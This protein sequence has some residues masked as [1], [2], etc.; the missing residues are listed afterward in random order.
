VIVHL[1]HELSAAG[2]D[3]LEA[4]Q[5]VHV[6]VGITG[7]ARADAPV[8]AAHVRAGFHVPD[9]EIVPARAARI[10]STSD[11]DD[12]VRAAIRQVVAWMHEGVN[13]GR[14]AVLH[15]A[16]DP[17]ARLVHEQLAAAGIPFN[18][19][20]VRQLGDLLLGRTL[21]ALLD[22]PST[23]YRRHEVL[24]VL[25]GAPL[26]DA[27]GSRVPSRA[28][29]RIS[30]E[31]GVVKGDHWGTRLARLAQSASDEAQGCRD[32]G[33]D[34]RADRL[35]VDA[36]RAEALAAWV[37]RLQDDLAAG[38]AAGSWAAM[39]EWAEGL[40]DAYLGDERRR[41]SWPEEEQVAAQRVEAALERLAGLDAVGPAP[42]LEVFRR[43][44]DSE[45]DQGLRR[46]GR[47]G[48]GVL[49]G[50][51]SLAGGL[52]LDRVIVLGLAEGTF[53]PRRL[54]DSLLPDR[55]RA[56]AG[57][58]LA[59]R[60]DRVHDD[61]R[62]LLAALAVAGEAVLCQPRGDLRRSGE[63]PASRWLLADAAALAAVERLR[64]D[65]LAS[66]H[67]A[68]WLVRVASF[69]GGLARTPV[70][71][72]DQE[73]RL[74]AVARGRH[75]HVV[76]ADARLAAGLEVVRARRSA[77]FT[78][79]D[80]N[81]AGLGAE[82]ERP[83]KVSASGL[84]TW[85]GC[86][87][88]YFLQYV[89]GVDP[90]EEPEDLFEMAPTDRGT[91]VHAVLEDLVAGA[92][93]DGHPFDQWGPADRA[94][95]YTIAQRH[96]DAYE[97]DGRTG[98]A[99][100]WGRDQQRILR[101]L[102]DTLDLDSARLARGYRPLA[103]EHR[104]RGVEVKLP[105]GHL[106]DVRGFVDRV[107]RRPDGGVEVLDYKSTRGIGK[108]YKELSPEA[109]HG[110]GTLLQLYLYAKAAERD[111]PTGVPVTSKYWFTRHDAFAGYDVTPDVAVLVEEAI[112]RIV[113]GI[114]AGVFPARPPASPAWGY[115]DCWFCRPDGL[116]GTERRREW[117]RKRLAPAL[118]TYV[119]L[120]EKPG[121]A[122]ES[123]NG[124]AR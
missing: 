8:I 100:V 50:H 87:H 44:L 28:W 97:A 93:A 16:P 13:L 84:Q 92:I 101:E 42:T 32:Q 106:L 71:A 51:V 69:A 83:V 34:W 22:L 63:R 111:F 11:P 95:L 14:V 3:L 10:I 94:S 49:V 70:L 55:E 115:V 91:L 18:G 110:D 90:V 12:E 72:T 6:N 113:D 99:L 76:L 60:A 17:Y 86:P 119:E 67:D 68:D 105:G 103:T 26:L 36:G 4:L 104:F 15:S 78:R 37:A 112:E 58:E 9:H 109:P 31:A 35:E 43:A 25:T 98:R 62:H 40:I 123:P 2:P 79:F 124:G 27:D 39:V 59:L 46:V 108:V 65:E 88:R 64:S 57:G 5:P 45:L 7:D 24:A 116:S 56:L 77:D 1:L 122:G 96:F 81:L 30:R 48:D 21:R 41:W 120:V 52:V 47:L 107:D 33:E 118:R 121:V 114:A 23:G 85:V 75:D 89:L 38:A 73:L 102:D 82:L 54:E 20:P 53:P 61:R 74:A 80:G 29:E 19:T 117:E 66:H